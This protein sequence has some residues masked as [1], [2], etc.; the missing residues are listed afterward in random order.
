M[1]SSDTRMETSF[2]FSY[3]SDK[4]FTYSAFYTQSESKSEEVSTIFGGDTEYPATTKSTAYGVN[5]SYYF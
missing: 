4:G 2:N 1:S 5:V 3:G